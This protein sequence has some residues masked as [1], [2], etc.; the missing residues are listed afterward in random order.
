MSR[1][2]YVPMIQYSNY[3][4]I[5]SRACDRDR[6]TAWRLGDVSILGNLRGAAV[7]AS[8]VFFLLKMDAASR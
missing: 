3:T 8:R 2:Q 1:W 5:Y 6:P 4:G 7:A